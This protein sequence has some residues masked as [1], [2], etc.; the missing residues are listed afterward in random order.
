MSSVAAA[1]ADEQWGLRGK[2]A[3]S[4]G[5]D[6]A[7]ALAAGAPPPPARIRVLG[8][9]LSVVTEAQVVEH[10][11][12]SSLAGHGGWVITPNLDHL[13]LF[14]QTPSLRAMFEA[15]ALVT[16]DGMPLVWA[17]RLQRT[18]LPQRVS[19]SAL[20]HSLTGAAARAG[21]SV[22]FLGGNPSAAQRT[23]EQLRSNN[24]ALKVAG[25]AC[26]PPGFDQDPRQ[27]EAIRDQLL[28]TRPD[29]VFVGLGF[30]KQER[31]IEQLRAS[32]PAAWFLGI[33][34]SFS[35]VCGQVRRAPLWMQRA[36]LEW[37]HRLIQ[38]PGRLG[39]RY[40]LHG[41]PFA[42]RLL[43]AAL[44]TRVRRQ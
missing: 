10:I 2:S 8:M 20:I 35:F 15:A 6:V 23:A 21:L 27:I 26:P 1:P 3:G 24:P 30:P 13:R 29:I 16:A 34:I 37:L 18:P 12:R 25:T 42:A 28:A 11:V 44:R 19:G 22:F 17:S 9:P 40:L 33:G 36:G 14:R 32:L 4:A 7:R 43:L 39:K 5:A 31:L 38:E 41:I